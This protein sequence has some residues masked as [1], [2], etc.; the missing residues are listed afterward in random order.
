MEITGDVHAKDIN[1]GKETDRLKVDFAGRDYNLN[2][3]NI[4]DNK[5][6]TVKGNEEVTYELTNG[7]GGHNDGTQLKGENTYLVGPEGPTP[8]P[9]P[10]PIPTPDPDDNENVKVLR[11]FENK[12][13]DLNQVYTPVAYAADLDDDKIDKGVRKN[14]D[15]SVT[16]VKAFPMI[17]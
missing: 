14:V 1:V 5:V 6:V 9:G 4:R 17:N 7:K 13:V 15:G 2:Y 16:V 12:S 8:P 3:T 11:S 10:D